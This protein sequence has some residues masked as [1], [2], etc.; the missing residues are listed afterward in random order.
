VEISLTPGPGRRVGVRGALPDDAGEIARVQRATWQVAY[1]DLLPTGVLDGWDD[2]ATARAWTT[3]IERPPS[4]EHRVLVAVDGGTVVGFAAVGPAEGPGAT[5][6]LVT[7]VVEPRWGRRGHGSRL[8]AA[9]TDG[10][11]EAGTGRMIMWVPEADE[12]TARFLA[13]AGWA[14]EG[15][16]RTLDAGTTTIRQLCW[17]T[18][19]DDDPAPATDE[20]AP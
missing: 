10:A 18:L 4:R 17:Q 5:A 9:A 12:V 13:G 16:V 20:G 7:L 11:R 1:R 15:R 19:L 8:L 6:E 2:A 14:P 3:A